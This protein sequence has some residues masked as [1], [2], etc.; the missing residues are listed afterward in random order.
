[1][2]SMQQSPDQV[3]LERLASDTNRLV[4]I[5]VVYALQEIREVA[6]EVA[7][8][9][10]SRLLDDQS[11]IVRALTAQALASTSQQGR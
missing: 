2:L 3:L 10:G 11:A 4:R 5:R 9:I 1:M 6:P 8:C 7:E